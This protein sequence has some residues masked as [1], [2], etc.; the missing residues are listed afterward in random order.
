[1]TSIRKAWL[2]S[3]AIAIP[4]LVA[5]G[6]AVFATATL[7]VVAGVLIGL[8]AALA[9]AV[10][11]EAPLKSLASVTHR[12]A[13]GDRY[14]ILPRQTPGPLAAIARSVDG[15]RAAVLEADALAVDQR[16]REAESRLHMA[17]RS[18]F[19]RSFRG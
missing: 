10:I 11:V 14:A 4:L 15:L 6:L 19:T 16:R 5:A 17:S 13:H 7:G 18:F 1:M 12:I 3:A 8:G 9:A 2:P